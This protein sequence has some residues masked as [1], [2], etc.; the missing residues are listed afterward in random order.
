VIRG[1]LSDGQAQKAINIL[2][3]TLPVTVPFIR[4]TQ[5]PP[6]IRQQLFIRDAT[7]LAVG[8]VGFLGTQAGFQQLSKR[9]HWFKGASGQRQLVSFLLAMA[10]N[11]LYGSLGA[12]RLSVWLDNK[13]K[14]Q[15]AEP[16]MDTK[17]QASL[18]PNFGDTK[19]TLSPVI[20]D[21]SSMTLQPRL[22]LRQAH[23]IFRPIFG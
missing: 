17:S 14:A 19:P 13:L 5:D 10:G 3:W 21:Y 4:L 8:G 7:T 18:E 2:T 9:M 16:Q 20:Q 22:N 1:R 12:P 23:G 6:E 11:V 15:S